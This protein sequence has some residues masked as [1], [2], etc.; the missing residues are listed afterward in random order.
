MFILVNNWLIVSEAIQKKILI[1]HMFS[2]F[3]QCYHSKT[4][5]NQIKHVL[6]THYKL[7]FYKLGEMQI[8]K[9]LVCIFFRE[10]FKMT[11]HEKFFE[12]IK[13]RKL[14]VS[15]KWLGLKYVF[16]VNFQDSFENFE[17]PYSGCSWHRT[18]TWI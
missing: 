2:H 10:N 11:W 6:K 18:V 16:F 13:A 8:N 3:K 15:I 14:F 12:G 7:L 4:F 17:N 9:I 1:T 5:K